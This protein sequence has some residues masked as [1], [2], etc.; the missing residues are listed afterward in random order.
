MNASRGTR[1]AIFG[2]AVIGAFLGQSGVALA[3][4]VETTPASSDGGHGLRINID[5]GA[6]SAGQ[7][8]REIAGQTVTSDRRACERLSAGNTTVQSPA[9]VTFSAGYRVALGSGFRV[10]RGAEFRAVVEP[11]RVRGGFVRDDSPVSE[12]HYAVRFL[13]NPDNLTM[14]AGETVTIFEAEDGLGRAWL[15]LDMRYDGGS[16]TRRFSVVT[17][18]GAASAATPGFDARAG[19]QS[20][21]IEW[22]ASAP[23]ASDGR[24][25][26]SQGGSARS[27]LS[28]LDNAAGRVDTVRWGVLGALSTTADYLDLD[29]FVSRR[30]GRIGPP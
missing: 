11:G 22:R 16:N 6:C 17:P 5:G 20:I 30:A 23:G 8:E 14:G 3:G 15:A 4:P 2:G 25:W 19:W 10:E 1:V 13:V 7:N 28:G 29:Q 24:V 26:V 18:D 21:E 12:T 27:G 9:S